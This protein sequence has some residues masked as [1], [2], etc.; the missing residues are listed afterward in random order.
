MQHAPRLQTPVPV[1]VPQLTDCPHA[2]LALPQVMVPHEAAGHV[3]HVPL[4]HWLPMPQPPQS[5]LALPHALRIAPHL[6]PVSPAHSGGGNAH[7]PPTHCCPVG[8]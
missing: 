6:G 2:L 4:A 7:T 5:T 8:H 1:H 3:V